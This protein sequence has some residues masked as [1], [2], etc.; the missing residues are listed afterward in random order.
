MERMWTCLDFS[1]QALGTQV[2]PGGFRR[3]AGSCWWRCQDMNLESAHL[4]GEHVNL[5]GRSKLYDEG[6]CKFKESTRCPSLCRKNVTSYFSQLY[7]SYHASCIEQMPAIYYYSRV[8]EITQSSFSNSTFLNDQMGQNRSIQ[9]KLPGKLRLRWRCRNVHTQNWCV[10]I[11]SMCSLNHLAR[12]NHSWC[13][14]G[15][16]IRNVIV[17]FY[18][19][20]MRIRQWIRNLTQAC[21]TTRN[22]SDSYNNC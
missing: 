6:H 5:S 7:D 1:L 11:N 17:W 19:F 15:E 4:H 21:L 10:T 13:A 3:G 8:A 20:P 9:F 18:S 16:W 14:V 2:V 12:M 22:L